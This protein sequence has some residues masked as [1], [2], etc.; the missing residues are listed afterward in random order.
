MVNANNIDPKVIETIQKI[1]NFKESSEAI[2]NEPQ[3][4]AAAGRLQV[5]LM[6]HN[7]TLDQVKKEKIEAKAKMDKAEFDVSS[8]QDKRESNWIPDLYYAIAKNFLCEVRISN[9]YIR[10]F[11][12]AHNV[13]LVLYI[14][15]Q[16]VAKVRIAEKEAWKIY[17][18]ANKGNEYAEKRGTFRRGFLQGCVKG[19]KYKLE[20]QLW[21]MK[22]SKEA[23]EDTGMGLMIVNKEQEVKDYLIEQGVIAKP[24]TQEEIMAANKEWDDW[25]NALDDKT[26]KSYEK[27]WAKNEKKQASRKGPR[28]ISSQDGY[29]LGR[30]AGDN[31]SINEGLNESKAK[32]QIN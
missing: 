30:E 14:A 9:T 24:R 10:V 15:E 26:R 23:N 20:E 11:G 2:G 32:G 19:I 22:Y 6:K 13:E 31:M 21:K 7:L 4:E 12:H 16:M 5:L 29:M 1:I 27:A 28:G 3:A 25:W 17:D 18:T 8:M